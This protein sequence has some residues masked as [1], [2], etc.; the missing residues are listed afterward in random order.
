M[1]KDKLTDYSATNASNTDVGGVNIDEGML[2]SSV[3]NA[4][5]ELMTHQANAFGAGTP[6]YVDETNDR[7]GIGTNSPASILHVKGRTLAVDGASASDSPRLNLDLDGT[8]K[9]SVLLNRVSEDLQVSAVGS[10]NIIFNTNSTER[11]RILSGG[12][13]TF[14]GDTAAANALDDA[15]RG[16]WTPNDSSGASL[17]FT[18]GEIAQYVK[19]GDLVC[20]SFYITY[21]TTASSASATIGG[22]PYT[23]TTG[24]CYPSGRIQGLGTSDI[25]AQINQNN[26]T[27]TLYHNNGGIQNSTLSGDYVIMSGCYIAA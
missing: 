3:N 15:E 4:I 6:L 10:N 9:A 21:P 19:V 27:M 2:P 22:L 5:R 16:T 11:M 1:P 14:N 7:L 12:G 17:T 25:V 23:A 13:I 26:T 24:Y 18:T 8:N 20:F